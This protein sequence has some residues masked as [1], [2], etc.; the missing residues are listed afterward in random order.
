MH[1]DNSLQM[2]Q[3]IRARSFKVKREFSQKAEEKYIKIK[4][5]KYGKTRSKK[6]RSKER[7]EVTGEVF[8]VL[9]LVMD[10]TKQIMEDQAK[11]SRMWKH[12]SEG[13]QASIADQL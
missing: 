13:G 9:N 2:G 1:E 11:A 3:N 5:K 8:L 10:K 7:R 12:H 6:G 4:R